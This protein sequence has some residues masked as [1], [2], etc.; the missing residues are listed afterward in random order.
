MCYVECFA[1]ELEVHINLLLDI[2]PVR[3]MTDIVSIALETVAIPVIR[4]RPL[5]RYRSMSATRPVSG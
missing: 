2:S 4:P 5:S 3:P 1:L